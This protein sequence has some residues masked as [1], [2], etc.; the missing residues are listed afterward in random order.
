MIRRHQASE[1][2]RTGLRLLNRSDLPDAGQPP[3]RP[4]DDDRLGIDR[5]KAGPHRRGPSL[6]VM[7]GRCVSIPS[8][9]RRATALA[10]LWNRQRGAT[11]PRHAGGPSSPTGWWWSSPRCDP[12]PGRARHLGG[13]GMVLAGLFDLAGQH[14]GARGS[15]AAQRHPAAVDELRASGLLTLRAVP[16]LISTAPGS[17]RSSPARTSSTSRGGGAARCQ[18]VVAWPSRQALDEPPGAPGG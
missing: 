18:A 10:Q 13:E 4:L 12:T 3:A 16:G 15:Q 5:S 17:G 11:A 9:P 2:R 7:C 14:R 6:P 8:D 1:A